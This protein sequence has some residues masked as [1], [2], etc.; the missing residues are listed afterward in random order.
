MGYLQIACRIGAAFAPWVTKWLITIHAALPFSV[1]GGSALICAIF[2]YWL[3]ET[4]N[5]DT[6]E[7]L[8]DQLDLNEN[9]EFASLID[10]EE[11]ES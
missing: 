10:G 5:I 2:L 11:E 6:M 8:H 9:E 7:T 3:P 1:M 4:A